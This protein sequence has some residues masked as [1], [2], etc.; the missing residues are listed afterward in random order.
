[1]RKRKIVFIGAGNVA[2]HLAPALHAQGA[3]IQI[4]SPSGFSAQQLAQKLG[5]CWC[6]SYNEIKK[7]ADFYLICTKDDAIVHV[8]QHI[9]LDNGIWLH[10]SGSVGIE[11]FC[12]RRSH[13]GILYPLQSFTKGDNLT[14]ESIPFLIEGSDNDT[15]LQIRELADSISNNV[16]NVD[17]EKRCAIH[18]AAV[19]ASN[20]T[21]F[22]L[23]AS[24]RILDSA[25]LPLS[26]LRPLVEVTTR[27]AFEFS[28]ICAQTGPARRGDAEIIRKHIELLADSPFQDVYEMLSTKI[29]TI[30]TP[31]THE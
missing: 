3:A 1:M 12:N 31:I 18:L 6:N 9:P 5:C 23:I 19:F 17:S 22:M 21:N 7:D 25:D 16:V 4:F 8:L 15:L 29:A 13:Y 30:Y 24:E 28:P 14:L 11:V 10:T 27:K 20:F 26:L 2:S